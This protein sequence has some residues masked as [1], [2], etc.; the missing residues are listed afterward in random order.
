MAND[1]AGA[2]ALQQRAVT[3]ECLSEILHSRR[4][5]EVVDG[6]VGV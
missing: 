2:T 5:D 1:K 6:T 4:V 3:T